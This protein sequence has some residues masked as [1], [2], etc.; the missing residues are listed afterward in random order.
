MET[1]FNSILADRVREQFE[2]LDAV[3]MVFVIFFFFYLLWFHLSIYI[4]FYGEIQ[5]MQIEQCLLPIMP[6]QIE[7]NFNS[8]GFSEPYGP[9][10]N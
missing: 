4:W 6:I 2:F 1:N 8:S 5:L 3:K 7:Y 10:F 9:I